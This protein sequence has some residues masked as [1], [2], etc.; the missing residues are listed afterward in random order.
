M[1]QFVKF[2]IVGASSTA[3]STGIFSWLIYFQHLD[4]RMHFWLAGNPSLQQAVD[5]YQLYIQVA[6]LVA[7]TVAVT[8]GFIWN[9]RWTFRHH[10]PARNRERFVKFILVNMVGLL[11]N[12]V[13]L[14]F[15]NAM[16]TGGGRRAE[17]GLEPLIAFAA[18]TAIVVFWNFLGNK[19]WTFKS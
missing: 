2:C 11:L 4:R 7:F 3:I 15:V 18:A 6:A 19:H 1:R 10:D 16:L 17:K 14:F 8:N 12:Q 9:N 13:I 5:H